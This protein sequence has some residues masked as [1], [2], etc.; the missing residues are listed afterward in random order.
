M[1]LTTFLARLSPNGASSNGHKRVVDVGWLI[2]TGSAGFIWD[3]PVLYK[4]ED[5]LPAHAK[6]AAYCPA[7]I[8]NERRLV[9]VA[10]PFD[11]RLR[12]SITDKGEAVLEDVDGI[13][14]GMMPHVL[15]K[16][17]KVAPRSEWR[18]PQRP[19]FQFRTPYVFLSDMPVY[20]A[21]LPPF[22]E[23]RDP[24][25]PGVVIGGRLPIH[26]WPRTLNWAFEWYDITRELTLTRGR[27]WFYCR[28]ETADPS[29]NIRLVE[30]SLTPE[31]KTY[32]AGI[33]SVV[34]YVNGTFSLFS[35]A[36][37]RRPARL[38]VQAAKTGGA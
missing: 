15:M 29:H 20:L 25:W 26:I 30:A 24:A 32:M 28:F 35:T 13:K 17:T 5:K 16:L 36:R 14:S 23:Y 9:Q 11:L 31:L 1:S 21:Q 19:I 33:E 37:R 8:D 4:R 6:S 2:R 22:L 18:H 34:E 12:M 27:P 10:C 38:L 3:A 7:V